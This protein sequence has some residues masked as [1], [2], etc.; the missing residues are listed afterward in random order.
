MKKILLLTALFIVAATTLSGAATKSQVIDLPVFTEISLRIPAK[1]QLV[2]GPAS[3]IE[4]EA[5][6]A[7]LNEL[8][9]EVKGRTLILRFPNRSRFNRSFIAGEIT[10]KVTTPEITALNISG[11]GDILSDRISSLILDLNISGSGS[12]KIKQ[13]EAERVKATISGSGDI[14]IDGGARAA[15]FN[16]TIS[17]SG[18]IRAKDYEAASVSA[19]IAGSGN[20]Y[21]RAG[22]QLIGRIA[23]SGNIY[24]TGN[25]SID[26]SVAGSGKV[27]DS[28]R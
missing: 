26:I 16:G 1:V 27:V 2:Q 14:V 24:Y 7:T 18:N 21:I 4:I 6:Q 3:R 20:T 25:P 15:E 13:L 9:A 23:G 28:N 12:V 5:S 11:S 22:A 8:I 10:I 17:G 19:R